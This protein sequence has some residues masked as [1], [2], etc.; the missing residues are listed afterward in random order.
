MNKQQLFTLNIIFIFVFLNVWDYFLSREFFN[1]MALGVAM[2]GP[3]AV[4]WKL[5]KVR[6]EV[7]ITLISI[8]EFVGLFVF[9]IEGFSLS[10]VSYTSKSIFWVPFLVIAGINAYFGMK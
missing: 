2:F 6:G 5:G 9:I 7:L 4:L 3:T 1:A 10:G 8:F